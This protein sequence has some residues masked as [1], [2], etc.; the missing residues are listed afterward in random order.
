MPIFTDINT[1][2]KAHP[3]TGDI[4]KKTDVEA[5]KASMRTILFSG[6][7]DSPFDPNYGANVKGML[8]EQITPAL[9]GLA[10]RK[11]MLALSEYEPR[12]IVEDVFVGEDPED[13]H[14]LLIGILFHVQGNTTQEVLNFQMRRVR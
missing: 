2:L 6:P 3:G 7:Y 13:E 12:C 11:I 8:F 14:G 10:K 5:V 1:T 4:L 9:M